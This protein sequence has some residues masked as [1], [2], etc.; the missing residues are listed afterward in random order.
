[1]TTTLMTGELKILNAD[2]LEPAREALAKAGYTLETRLSY[3]ELAQMRAANQD[4]P[5]DYGNWP[6]IYAQ[7]ASVT[8][9]DWRTWWKTVD[10]ILGEYDTELDQVGPEKNASM[11]EV[12]RLRTIG[13]AALQ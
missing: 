2:H 7:V 5:D 6:I 9:L 8:E 12:D 13:T 10:G 4:D 11:A 3:H 1:M